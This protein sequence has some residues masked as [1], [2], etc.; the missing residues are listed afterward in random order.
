[1]EINIDSWILFYIYCKYLHKKFKTLLPITWNSKISL[2]VSS[3]FIFS[4]STAYV[5]WRFIWNRFSLLDFSRLRLCL[6]N[7]PEWHSPQLAHPSAGK[8]VKSHEEKRRRIS[9]VDREFTFQSSSIS[10]P[11]SIQHLL[12]SIF[13]FESFHLS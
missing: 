13:H 7:Q 11:I 1:M 3:I 10:F 12:I 2:F 6:R 8:R 5:W 4:N 9:S